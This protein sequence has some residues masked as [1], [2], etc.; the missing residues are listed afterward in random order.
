LSP[1][2]ELWAKLEAGTQEYQNRISGCG[3]PL[4]KILANILLVARRRPVVI[5]SL[6]PEINGEEPPDEEI[7]EYAIRLR[8]LKRAGAQISLVQIY[9]AT[10]P[11]ARAGCSHLPLRT[12]SEIAQTVRR[13]SGLRAEVF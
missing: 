11:M 4:E 7:N 6:F 5:Q 13:V 10:R 1:G 3:V 8:E 12:L 2:D 9:S